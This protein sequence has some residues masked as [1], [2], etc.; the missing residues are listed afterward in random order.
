MSDFGW[1]PIAKSESGS[2]HMVKNVLAKSL[3]GLMKLSD[4]AN[5]DLCK[6]Q[7]FHHF[8]VIPEIVF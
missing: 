2:G 4:Y 6:S 7:L 3:F 8:F 5:N 1:H